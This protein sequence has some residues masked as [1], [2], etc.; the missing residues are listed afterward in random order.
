MAQKIV[1]N[2]K[3]C[4]EVSTASSGEEC[5]E[6]I[7][8]EDFDV[9]LLDIIMLKLNGL[10]VLAKMKEN[11]ALSR[12]KVIM[13]TSL[14]DRNALKESFELGASDYINKPIE[15]IEFTARIRSAIKQKNLENSITK[16]FKES[17][18]KNRELRELYEKL[19][20]A[21]VQMIEREKLIGIG[22]LASGIAHEINN[23]LGFVMSNL[24]T[25]TDY[26][27]SI[28][29]IN[30]M[31][32]AWLQSQ[33]IE[34]PEHIKDAMDE[35]FIENIVE[36]IPFI[37]KDMKDGLTRIKEVVKG[38]RFFSRVD[39]N[40][41]IEHIDF[42]DVLNSIMILTE[43][44]RANID[45]KIINQVERPIEC[46]ASDINKSVLNIVLNSIQAL[47]ESDAA[48]KSLHINVSENQGN[49]ICEISDNGV[50]ISKKHIDDVFNPFF[51]TKEVG[52]GSG[53]GLTVVYETIVN[54]HKG[55]VDIVSDEGKGTI[56]RFSIPLIFSGKRA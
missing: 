3:L 21:Q 7:E 40:G 51:T 8:K 44:D 18:E 38:V 19:R 23:P 16:Q 54:K 13:F 27:A 6:M 34:L 20:K 43:K 4:D 50:G 5:L 28:E 26:Y 15:P 39:S 29:K 32:E 30:K 49:L 47:E 22:Q 17:I 31:N 2:Y 36:D 41:E 24:A 10:Q 33:K 9:V 11:G 45:T 55:S 42:E 48:I 37:F 25:L 12:M 35:E 46:I 1:E 56:V 14:S 52:A 53:L